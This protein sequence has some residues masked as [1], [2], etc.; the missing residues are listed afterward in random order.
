LHLP[1]EYNTCRAASREKILERCTSI[2]GTEIAARASAIANDVCAYAPG[3]I[4][5]ASNC[6]D[7]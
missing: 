4:I 6:C 1:A 7:C 5:P 2:N 3:L